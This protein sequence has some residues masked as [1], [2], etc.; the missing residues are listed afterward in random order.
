MKITGYIAD[1]RFLEPNLPEQAFSDLY[2][3]LM[4]VFFLGFS[5]SPHALTIIAGARSSSH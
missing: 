4:S 1:G 2:N 5:F 3:Q